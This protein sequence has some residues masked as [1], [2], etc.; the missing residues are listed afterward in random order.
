M[1]LLALEF[2]VCTQGDDPSAVP[3]KRLVF[4]S[5]IPLFLSNGDAN[6]PHGR[7]PEVGDSSSHLLGAD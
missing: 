2:M 6:H 7:E 3:V 1:F 4:E 5:Y